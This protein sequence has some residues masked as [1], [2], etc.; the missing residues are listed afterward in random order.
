MALPNV[1][2]ISESTIID[3][4]DVGCVHVTGAATTGCNGVYTTDGADPP[5]FTH[6]DD[7]D[8]TIVAS[9]NDWSMKETTTTHYQFDGDAVT[10]LQIPQSGGAQ[11]WTDEGGGSPVPTSRV[12]PVLPSRLTP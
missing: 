2:D 11:V 7:S 12:T 5:T 1:L 6:V 8:F 9:G 3:I 4:L 10:G